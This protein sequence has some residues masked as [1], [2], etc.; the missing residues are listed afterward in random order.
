MGIIGSIGT[1]RDLTKLLGQVVKE[2]VG[3]SGAAGGGLVPLDEKGN[4]LGSGF[5][6]GQDGKY[7]APAF[8]LRNLLINR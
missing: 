6:F 3:I 2:T 8:F 1:E 4:F 7:K 5:I